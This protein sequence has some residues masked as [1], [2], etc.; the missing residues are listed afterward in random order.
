MAA[1][2]VTYDVPCN[3]N[4]GDIARL[5]IVRA[6]PLRRKQGI[7]YERLDGKA[8]GVQSF[9]LTHGLFEQAKVAGG[10]YGV[11]WND[12]IDISCNE[13]YANGKLAAETTG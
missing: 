4:S 8:R 11:Y 7:R 13:L 10:G 1:G 2:N 3:R 5:S 6:V 9:R 12:Y